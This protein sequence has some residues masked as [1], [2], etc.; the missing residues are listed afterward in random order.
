MVLIIFQKILS[1]GNEAILVTLRK[2]EKGAII[3]ID[4]KTNKLL[5]KSPKGFFLFPHDGKFTKDKTITV[6]DNGVMDWR[7]KTN[8]LSRI[9]ELNIKTNKIVWEYNN[10]D[11]K[12]KIR[13]F[14]QWNFFFTMAKWS[15]KNRKR[16]LNHFRNVWKN[17]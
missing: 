5:W 9:F 17:L 7:T 2:F 16:V 11:V 8:K 12:G 1:M 13:I 6:F 3:L 14:F 15:S 4:L 10:T